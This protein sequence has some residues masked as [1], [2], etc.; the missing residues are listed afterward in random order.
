MQRNA[1]P[2]D[3]RSWVPVLD[4]FAALYATGERTR[5]EREPCSLKDLQSNDRSFPSE[6]D[7]PKPCHASNSTGRM[8]LGT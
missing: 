5:T 2:H 3:Q 4:M 8:V 1:E 7:S 6:K